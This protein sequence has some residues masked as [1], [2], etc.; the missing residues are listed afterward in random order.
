MYQTTIKKAVELVGIGLH[1][2][3]AVKLRLEPL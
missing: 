3:S 2:G 1:K